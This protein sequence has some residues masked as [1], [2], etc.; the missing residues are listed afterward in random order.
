MSFVLTE[1]IIFYTKKLTDRLILQKV[2][3]AFNV[4]NLFHTSSYS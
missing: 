2:C 3:F 1:G 4:D